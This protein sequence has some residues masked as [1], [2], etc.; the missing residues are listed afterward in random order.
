M[1]KSSA[2]PKAEMALLPLQR[3]KVEGASM[4]PALKRGDRLLLWKPG[5]VRRSDIIVFSATGRE[6]VKRVVGLPGET[7]WQREQEVTLGK[8]EYFVAGDNPS[9]S[10]DSRSFGPIRRSQIRGRVL[11]R[12]LPRPGRVR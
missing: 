11:L 5:A 12:Y 2:S 9:E 1:R 8:D 10:T 3:Y 7:L 6:M 4:E